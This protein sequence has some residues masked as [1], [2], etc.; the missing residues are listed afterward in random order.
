MPATKHDHLRSIPGT[1]IVDRAGQL[2]YK[3]SCRKKD[4]MN[5]KKFKQ[6]SIILPEN[7][8]DGKS[9][10]LYTLHLQKG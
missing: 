6:H 10:A 5:N 9:D 7:F 8:E 4:Y 1:Q 2:A 3:H